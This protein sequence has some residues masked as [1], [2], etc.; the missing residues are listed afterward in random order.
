MQDLKT[1]KGLKEGMRVSVET[2]DLNRLKDIC[3]QGE[4]NFKWEDGVKDITVLSLHTL[5]DRLHNA[6]FEEGVK[7]LDVLLTYPVADQAHQRLTP[8]SRALNSKQLS[9]HR[10]KRVCRDLLDAGAS[11][12][13]DLR[14]GNGYAPLHR[15]AMWGEEEFTEMFLDWGA[16]IEVKDLQGLTPLALAVMSSSPKATQVLLKRGANIHVQGSK[17]KTPFGDLTVGLCK[18]NSNSGFFYSST[19]NA[20]FEFIKLGGNLNELVETD[21]SSTPVTIKEALLNCGMLG[22]VTVEPRPT[23]LPRAASI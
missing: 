8:L 1:L 21:S 13:I 19:V 9:S 2:L 20:L 18:L 17:S 22:L 12:T 16:D 6:N 15:A 23:S 14:D 11:Q 3:S 5:I 4:R 10:L 7:L